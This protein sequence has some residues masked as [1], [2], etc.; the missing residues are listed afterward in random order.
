[1]SIE[2]EPD[3]DGYLTYKN[4]I[5]TIWTRHYLGL[6]EKLQPIPLDEFKRFFD[7]LW[8]DKKQPHKTSPSMKTSLL[9]WLSDKT[10]RTHFEISRD[11]G[12]SLEN[13]FNEIESEYGNVSRDD[14]DPRYAH[15][16]LIT[17]KKDR[18]ENGK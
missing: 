2:P 9:N 5:L 6:T 11:L 17:V 16:F 8:G 14:L 18:H 13:L 3:T 12:P 15:L 7:C 10:G 4:Y 1:M